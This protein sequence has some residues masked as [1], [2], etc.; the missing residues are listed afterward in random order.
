MGVGFGCR[1]G[2]GSISSRCRVDVRVRWVSVWF[3]WSR[4]GLWW[5]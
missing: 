1:V 3:R 5:V 2:L 4:V